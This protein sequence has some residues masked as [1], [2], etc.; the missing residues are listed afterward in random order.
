MVLRSTSARKY[1]NG[2]MRCLLPKKEQIGARFFKVCA[3]KKHKDFGSKEYVTSYKSMWQPATKINNIRLP[4]LYIFFCNAVCVICCRKKDQIGA[5]FIK[6]LCC[7]FQR[8]RWIYTYTYLVPQCHI[9]I[10]N[11]QT[12]TIRLKFFITG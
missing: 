7:I 4:S 9:S 8:L 3:A 11:R 6:S 5:R 1:I 2:R 10:H 12:E